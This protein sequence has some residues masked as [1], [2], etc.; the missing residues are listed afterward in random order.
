MLGFSLRYWGPAIV[1]FG[2]VLFYFSPECVTQLG[3]RA[4]R[5]AT[6]RKAK[7]QVVARVETPELVTNEVLRLGGIFTGNAQ[8]GAIINGKYYRLGDQVGT[9]IIIGI[10]PDSVLLEE[11]GQQQIL[12][13]RESVKT[14]AVNSLPVIPV[15][16]PTNA[17]ADPE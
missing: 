1:L 6:A 13:M 7:V 16:T 8:P 15:E 17:P 3:Q 11:N 4:Q 9:A 5:W 12:K 10:N 2:I 14:M